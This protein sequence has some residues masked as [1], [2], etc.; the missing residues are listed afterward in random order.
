MVNHSGVYSGDI[1]GLGDF[2][3]GRNTRRIRVARFSW[4]GSIASSIL[5]IPFTAE[6]QCFS[7]CVQCGNK[8]WVLRVPLCSRRT[9]VAQ[10]QC[11]G[12]QTVRVSRLSDCWKMSEYFCDSPGHFFCCLRSYAQVA[13]R[14]GVR[15]AYLSTVELSLFSVGKSMPPT[16]RVELRGALLCSESYLIVDGCASEPGL[17]RVFSNCSWTVSYWDESYAADIIFVQLM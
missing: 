8:W 14:H 10:T 17:C 5:Y 7:W 11:S 4:T 13:P 3:H 9:S 15:R 1:S 16:A 6:D 2:I 12:V